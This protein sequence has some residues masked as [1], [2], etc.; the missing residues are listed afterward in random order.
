[1]IKLRKSGRSGPRRTTLRVELDLDFSLAAIVCP[2]RD[3]RMAWQLNQN[4][5]MQL[6]RIEDMEV[7]GRRVGLSWFSRYCCESALDKSR[8]WL[9]SNRS[10]GEYLIPE[11]RNIDYFLLVRGGWYENRLPDLLSSVR[12]IPSVQTVF[13]EDPNAL[14]SRANLIQE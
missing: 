8:I 13:T 7:E 3:Y 1:M 2:L 10:G 12:L 6:R 11:R 4:F 9:I 5:R 14:R